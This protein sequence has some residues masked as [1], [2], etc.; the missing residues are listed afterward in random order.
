MKVVFAGGGTGGHIYPA[1]AVADELRKRN[2]GL[3]PVFI[4]TRKGLEA[5]VVPESGYEIGFVVSSGFRGKGILGKGATLLGIGV[6]SIQAIAILSRLKARLVF[7]SGGFASAS[8]IIAAILMGIP[9]VIQE[10]NSI[11]GMTNRFLYKRAKRVYIGFQRAAQYFKGNSAVIYTGNPLR[12]ELFEPKD[13]DAREYFGLKHDIP[14]LLVFGGSR[15]AHSINVVATEY[16]LSNGEVQGIVQ[17]GDRDYDWVKE[18]LAPL[19]G[20]VVV[21][22]YMDKIDLAYRAADLALARAGALSVSELAA[23][24]LPSILVPYPYAVDNHQY[25]NALEIEEAG[26][27]VIIRD[28][29]LTPG[30]FA[31]TASAI[32]KDPSKLDRMKDALKKAA[33]KDAS[34][35]IADDIENLLEGRG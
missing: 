20:R 33:V 27:A 24:H 35:R 4:G 23:V 3:E 26:G 2:R 1:I 15:G 34:K 21:R 22:R 13:I 31:E 12:D 17:T 29:E 11:P 32:I 9:V 10:Q 14:V 7:G 28:Q 30:R 25:Y 19:G 5:K 18:K 8:T 6:G 16:F